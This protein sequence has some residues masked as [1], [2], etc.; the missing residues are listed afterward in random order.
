[1]LET[2]Y[3][4]VL[5]N[6]ANACNLAQRKADDLTLLAV[7]KFHSAQSVVEIAKLG[8]VH[9]AE[10]Y[11]KEAKEKKLQVMDLLS[12][13][14]YNKIQWHSIGHIQTNKAKDACD[15]YCLIHALD[16][17]R[18]AIALHKVLE[19]KEQKQDILLE[20]NIANEAQKAGLSSDDCP[21]LIEKI[22]ELPYLQIKGFMCLPPLQEKE[23]DSR[24]YFK[25]LYELRNKME[26]KFQMKFPHLSMGTSGDYKEAILEGATFVRIGTD[27]FGERE[28]NN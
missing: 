13:E 26:D 4:Q 1:M 8:Q 21:Y 25:A 11:L 2:N 17:E 20:I 3:R 5:E 24:K 9:F 15:N 22:L 6:I 28:Y 19:K 7:S 10:S 16:S 12:E 27:I 23:G 14:E 18:L